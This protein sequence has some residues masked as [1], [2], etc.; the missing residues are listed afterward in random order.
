MRK[1]KVW[2]KLKSGLYGWKSSVEKVYKPSNKTQPKI[3][4]DPLKAQN[5]HSLPTWLLTAGRVGEGGE[6]S[7][8][9]EIFLPKN[10]QKTTTNIQ[11]LNTKQ[12]FAVN[13]DYSELY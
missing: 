8:P 3:S 1:N 10:C 5:T 9:S 7:V 11:T 12:Y 13:S 4:S 6:E 2:T